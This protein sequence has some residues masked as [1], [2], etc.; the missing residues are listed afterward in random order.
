MVKQKQRKP[1]AKKRKEQ[2][3]INWEPKSAHLGAKLQNM[4][5]QDMIRAMEMYEEG[6]LS[7]REIS[8]Q[9]GIHVATLNKQFRG[10]VKG[11]G[12]CLGRKQVPKVLMQGT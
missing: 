4:T 6:K 2:H 1:K 9:T 7:Q 3:K 11:I 5:E 12:H 10:L 8:R